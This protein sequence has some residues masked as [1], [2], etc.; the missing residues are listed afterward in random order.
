MSE[1]LSRLCTCVFRATCRAGCEAASEE[2]RCGLEERGRCDEFGE[3]GEVE[4]VVGAASVIG[5]AE[6]WDAEGGGL[7]IGGVA[8]EIFVAGLFEEV[9]GVGSG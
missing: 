6:R 5:G 1:Q 8:E 4:V 2:S 9:G 3:L 7:G